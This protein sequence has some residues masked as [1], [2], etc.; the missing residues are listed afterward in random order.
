[1]ASLLFPRA[2]CIRTAYPIPRFRVPAF[3]PHNLRSRCRRFPDRRRSQLEISRVMSP[4]MS[5]GYSSRCNRLFPDGRS[6]GSRI[7]NIEHEYI[8]SATSYQLVHNTSYVFPKYHAGNG[9][10]VGILQ[11]RDCRCSF[12]RCNSGSYLQKLQWDVVLAEYVLLSGYKILVNDF[13]KQ[14]GAH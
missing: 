6:S 2:K 10:P 13:Q 4:S 1:M 8:S 9:H 7:S 3:M 12:A 5:Q 14:E 11:F